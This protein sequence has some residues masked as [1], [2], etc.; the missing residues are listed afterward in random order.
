[1]LSVYD[2]CCYENGRRR[3]VMVERQSCI[4]TV[5][6]AERVRHDGHFV[7]GR[8]FMRAGIRRSRDLREQQCP[9]AEQ[10]DESA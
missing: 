2:E 5:V 7:A 1:M 4:F 8:D 10:R 3:L 9:G 6:N